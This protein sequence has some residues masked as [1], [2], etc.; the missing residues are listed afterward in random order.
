VAK[1]NFPFI[2]P[3]IKKALNKILDKNQGI[4]VPSFIKIA[5]KLWP[6]DRNWHTDIQTSYKRI[7]SLSCQ[8]GDFARSVKK[9]PTPF[10]MILPYWKIIFSSWRPLIFS[11]NLIEN[12]LELRGLGI[13]GHHIADLV[14]FPPWLT[15]LLPFLTGL[16]GPLFSIVIFLLFSNFFDNRISAL[17]IQKN[18]TY[19]RQLF[20]KSISIS[21]WSFIIFFTMS[22]IVL[23]VSVGAQEHGFHV[24][25]DYQQEWGYSF[26]SWK[27]Q[28]KKSISL[29]FC[30]I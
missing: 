15:M 21:C 4:R 18:Y 8:I 10:F 28:W 11:T 16:S 30:D 17:R 2:F 14:Y 13:K 23:F 5:W 20:L 7:N 9:I 12:H 26:I 29:I 22:H 24:L 25:R 27:F 3:P 19:C 6:L 1:A